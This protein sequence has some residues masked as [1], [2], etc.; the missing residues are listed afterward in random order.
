MKELA[1]QYFHP[2]GCGVFALRQLSDAA[3]HQVMSAAII[4][5]YDPVNGGITPDGFRAAARQLGVKIGPY[6]APRR[7][8]CLGQVVDMSARDGSTLVVGVPDHVLVVQAGKRLDSN[9]TPPWAPVFM[10]AKVQ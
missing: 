7:P 9:P 2:K 3:D 10:I 5:G 8:V 6:L 4:N 1:I